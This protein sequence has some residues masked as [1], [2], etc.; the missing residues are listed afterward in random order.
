[1]VNVR[2]PLPLVARLDH[3]LDQLECQ[4]GLK[5]NRGMSTRRALELFLEAHT[6]SA[7][8]SSR[9]GKTPVQN[10]PARPMLRRRPGA[11]PKAQ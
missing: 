4:T 2:L 1:M 10:N 9:V 8:L 5:A 3:Y 7:A 6:G 11:Q